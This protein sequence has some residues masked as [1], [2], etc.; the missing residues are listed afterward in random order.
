MVSA[1]RGF[2]LPLKNA[3]SKLIEYAAP[4]PSKAACVLSMVFEMRHAK[5]P[6]TNMLD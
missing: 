6:E 2:I 1:L 3:Q 5:F 4:T